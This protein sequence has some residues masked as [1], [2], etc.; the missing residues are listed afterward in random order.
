M[1][2][3]QIIENVSWYNCVG[4]IKMFDK[5]EDAVLGHTS[6][7]GLIYP[8]YVYGISEVCFMPCA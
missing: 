6:V 8:C 4:H 7:V 3:K 2:S 5:K 1:A